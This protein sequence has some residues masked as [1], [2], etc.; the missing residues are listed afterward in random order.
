MWDM[1]PGDG[2]G[3]GIPLWDMSAQLGKTTMPRREKMSAVDTAWLRMDRPTNLMMIL[4]VMVFSRRMDFDRLRNTIAARLVARYRRFRQCAVQ[5]VG[6]AFWE[7]DPDFDIDAHLRRRALP[8]GS[9]KVALQALAGEL[10]VQPLNPG[11]PLWRFDLIEDYEGGSAMVVRI[12]HSI[13]D[14][15]A[16]VGV[17][18]SLT[19]PSPEAPPQM[20]PQALRDDEGDGDEPSR[21]LLETL[22]ESLGTAFH[23]G[24]DLGSK[25]LTLAQDTDRL[26]TYG[27]YGI[28]LLAELA[29]LLAMPPDSPTRL[30]GHTGTVKRVA[31]AEPLPLA[32]VKALGKALGCSVNDVLLSTVAGAIRAYLKQKGENV[33]GIEVRAMVPVNLRSAGDEG[34]LGNRFGLVTLSL[35][36]WEANPFARLF[37]VRERMNE[38]KHSFQPPLTLGVLAA[39]GLAPKLVQQAFLDMLAA[40]ASAVM[41]NVPGP[42][43]PLYLAGARVDQC[44]FWVPQSGDIGIGVSILSYNDA[45]QFSLISDRHFIPDPEAVTPLFAAEFEKMLL[46]LLMLEWDRPL[47]PILA[48][49][50][51]FGRRVT[52]VPAPR[53]PARRKAAPKSSAAA[54]SPAPSAGDTGSGSAGDMTSGPTTA[55]RIPKRFRK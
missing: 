42:K 17:V 7:D 10:A 5:E 23:A 29:K 54:V 34:T 41:T 25:A 35:P 50:Q 9:G 38:L 14:G 55:R 30:K 12:H 45:V 47:D 4:G 22:A 15:I 48:E 33:E 44:M 43:E 52:G 20:A 40:K 16:L 49:E 39:V 2:D 6:G 37:L 26:Q 1:P 53:K 24:S 11:K 19:D 36:I 27:Q 18:L 28:G 46:A 13:A 3:D 21:G 51:L 8:R 32:E 31:W